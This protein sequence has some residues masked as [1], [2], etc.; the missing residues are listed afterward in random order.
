MTPPCFSD[1]EGNDIAEVLRQLNVA[2]CAFQLRTIEKVLG[3][4]ATTTPPCPND[5]PFHVEGDSSMRDIDELAI[6]RGCVVSACISACLWIAIIAAVGVWLE[7][8]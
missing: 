2:K 4:G 6:W 8:F 1:G 3:C 7:W 5:R